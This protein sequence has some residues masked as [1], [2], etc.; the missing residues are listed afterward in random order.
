MITAAILEF[1]LTVL[2]A[3]LG[4]V[5]LPSPPGWITSTAGFIG[6]VYRGVSSMGV[7]FPGG[8]VITVLTAIFALRV[9]GLGLKIA[10]MGVSLFTGGGGN[11]T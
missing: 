10:R 3:A 2:G 4:G 6:T 7:W 5:N 1:C 9:T 8:L 11:A